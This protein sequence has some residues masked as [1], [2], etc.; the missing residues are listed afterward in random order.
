VV[1]RD[2]LETPR[3]VKIGSRI[4]YVDDVEARP[5]DV[6]HRQRRRHSLARGVLADVGRHGELALLEHRPEFL[7][8]VLLPVLE[9]VEVGHGGKHRPHDAL[10][11]KKAGPLACG[12]ADLAVGDEEEEPGTA[13]PEARLFFDRERGP[14][15]DHRLGELG[16]QELVLVRRADEAR[17]ALAVEV[18]SERAGRAHYFRAGA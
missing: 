18:G 7:L 10:D 3:V 13:A 4:S 16:D 17:V 5:E 1:R 15:D 9:A 12:R 14:M 2:L 6:G 11:G 8:E